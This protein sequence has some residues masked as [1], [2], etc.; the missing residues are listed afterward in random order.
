[1]CERQFIL[2][3]LKI[4]DVKK[5]QNLFD[6]WMK[7]IDALGRYKIDYIRSTTEKKIN[8]NVTKSGN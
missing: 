5:K 6:N 2:V 8:E 4:T 7:S 1:M 3:K